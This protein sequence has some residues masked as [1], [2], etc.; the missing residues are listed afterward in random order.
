[1]SFRPP[2]NFAQWIDENADSLRPPV[3]NK[4]I[5]EGADMMVTVVGGGNVRTDYH[6]DPREE[7]FYQLRG[8]M[9]LKVRNEGEPAVDLPIREGD[10]FL[11]PQHVR[12]SPQ[13]PDPDS[14]GLVVEYA[15][16]EGEVDGFEWFCGGCDQRVH[17]VEVQLTSLVR[18]LP[19]LFDA[20]YADLSARTCTGCGAIHP[21]PAGYRQR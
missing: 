9:T 12:H 4:Q 11:L 19:P 14:I 15:R 13:R 7:F 8:D 16:D 3:S 20:F 18:D 6:D 17:R 1:M 21:A 5:W 10:I 2:F